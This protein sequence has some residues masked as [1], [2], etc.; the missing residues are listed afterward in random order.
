MAV[1]LLAASAAAA[2]CPVRAQI[3]PP[4]QVPRLPI[5]LPVDLDKTLTTAAGALDPNKLV[6]L[7]RLRVRTLLREHRAL[8]ESDPRGAPIV[9]AEIT[10]FSPSPQAVERALAAGF[11][12]VRE[13]V[14]AGLDARV[15]VLRAPPRMATRVALK[16]LKKLDPEGTYDFNHIY[17]ESGAIGDGE[18]RACATAMPRAAP[19]PES[20][21][22][23][24]EGEAVAK[25]GLI[26]GGVDGAHPV[27]ANKTIHRHGCGEKPV[28]S[29]H[30]TA[31]ASLLA[32]RA[33]KFRGAAPDAELYA[34]DVYCG[35]PAGG[36]VDAIAEAFAWLSRE[37]VGVI[38]VSLV[39]PA[40]ALLENVVRLTVARGHIVVA[41][42]GND[43]PSAPPLYPA[44]YPEVIG[45]TGVDARHRVLLEAL[46]GRQVDFAA[47]GADLRAAS[48]SSAFAPVRGTSFAAPIVAGVLAADLQGPDR[49]AAERATARL[50]ARA[51]D[52][53]APGPD[54]VYGRGLVPFDG[55]E[56]AVSH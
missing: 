6:D 22:G 35:A 21:A 44:G 11:S 8:L 43:G 51:L 45:V 19:S 39:G 47:L 37:Q 49:G 40:N 5:K 2:A 36:A 3:V 53:G 18:T 34:A 1:V 26:D 41:A 17:L 10:A 52:L 30:G 33:E 23:V 55:P 13:R 56:A 14:L 7:R 28:A 46:R 38:N 12:I 50:A 9:R 16:Q 42:V 20:P 54:P 24:A 48:G 29:A 32:G 25:I 4:V 15:V 31:V 27:F